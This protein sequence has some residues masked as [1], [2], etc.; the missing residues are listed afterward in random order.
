M[1]AIDPM[2]ELTT[3]A[4]L[5]GHGVKMR[6][7]YLCLHPQNSATLSLGQRSFYLPWATVNAGSHDWSN[8]LRLS[9]C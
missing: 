4:L 6:S 2:G 7:K 8:V 3:V 9:D 5:S 1:A